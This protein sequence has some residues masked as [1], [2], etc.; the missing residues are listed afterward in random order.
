MGTRTGIVTNG[1]VGATT[2]NYQIIAET[3]NGGYTPASTVGS[4]ATGAAALG[5]QSSNANCSRANDVVTCTTSSAHGFLVGCTI[6][7]CG[8]VYTDSMSDFSFNGW[9]QVATAVDSTH[10]TFTSAIDTRQGGSAGPTTGGIAY[11]WNCNHLTWTAV[12][13]AWKYYIYGR[14]GGSLTLVGVSMPQGASITDT[15][16]DDFGS[17]MMDLQF[18]PPFIPT[19][20]PVSG[21][22]NHL[23]TTIASGAGTT[24]LTLAAAATTTVIGAT[25]RLDNTPNIL[26]AANAAASSAGLFQGGDQGGTIYFPPGGAA[27]AFPTASFL[28]LTTLPSVVAIAQSGMIWASETWQIPAGQSWHGNAPFPQKG[29]QPQFAFTGQPQFIVNG[30]LPGIYATNIGGVYFTGFN[31]STGF[32]VGNGAVVMF[33][34][35]QFQYT[36]DNMF[37][38]SSTNSGDYMGIDLYLR[39]VPLT[40]SAAFGAYNKVMFTGGPTTIPNGTTH[41]PLWFCNDCGTTKMTDMFIN[42]RGLNYRADPSGGANLDIDFVYQQGNLQPAI[43]TCCTA[44]INVGAMTLDSVPNPFIAGYMVNNN[45]PSY[46]SFTKQISDPGNLGPGSVASIG[47]LRIPTSGVA[48][49]INLAG[50]TNAQTEPNRDNCAFI[51]GFSWDNAFYPTYN[52]TTSTSSSLF[53]CY[54]SIAVGPN[55]SVMVPNLQ[56]PAPTCS[57]SAGGA[58]PVG[59]YYYRFTPIWQNN[60]E[61]VS[62]FTSTS[63]STT[64]GNQTVTISWTLV[65]GNAKGYD[66]YSSANGGASFISL[67][68]SQPAVGGTVTSFVFAGTPCG[69]GGSSLPSGGPTMLMPGTQGL[70]TPSI[71][72]GN[73]GLTSTITS[74][75]TA[76]RIVNLADNAGIIHISG[77]QETAFD[78]ANRADGAIGA[79]WTNVNNSLN[80]AS[81]QFKGNVAADNIAFWSGYPLSAVVGQSQFSEATQTVLSARNGPG[82][83]LGN[84]GGS[85]GY[86]CTENPTTL[87]IYDVFNG[88]ANANRS[89]TAVT[90]VSGDVLRAEVIPGASSNVI[91]CTLTQST[92]ITIVSWTDSSKLTTSGSPGLDIFSGAARFDNWSGGTFHPLAQLDQEQDWTQPQ[93]LTASLTVGN[94]VPITGTLPL[95]V[96]YASGGVNIAGGTSTVLSTYNTPSATGNANLTAT[97]MIILT[98][99][100]HTYTFQWTISLVTPGTSCTG[101]TTVELDAIYTDPNGAG[102]Q[103]QNLGVVTIASSGNG[104]AG[105]VATGVDNIRAKTGTAVQYQTS[106][107]TAGT[108]CSPAP[109]YKVYPVL[110]QV[111]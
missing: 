94:T 96:V 83:Y 85:G 20:P 5:R 68:C 87:A 57:V 93:H 109:T 111:N 17:P 70:A 34:E 54:A 31:L 44:V 72:M 90:G 7:N 74:A 92:G 52:G 10:F 33:G 41:T 51:G 63:C 56:P 3:K 65:P 64:P 15:T 107:F 38:G 40:Q 50:L 21:A 19:S 73:A 95:G 46:Y 13:G 16:F 100:E 75:P 6:V 98:S 77:A 35:G 81:N 60:S 78:N 45:G 88:A 103:T 22:A 86:L 53:S 4:T 105:M 8:E 84:S 69:V 26:T 32:S 101:N 89:S 97:S 82:V 91:N 59:T 24:T 30:A 49:R 12:T 29:V 55:N 110:S 25:I 80:I 42:H 106:N 9:W 99:A 104:T 79:N 66:I 11:W 43:T 37:F 2:Y 62:S 76:N 102:A 58:V 28:D 18:Y 39:G 71:L 23:V 27:V 36:F 1:P 14:T 61:G 48:Q 67:S 108:G 47:G